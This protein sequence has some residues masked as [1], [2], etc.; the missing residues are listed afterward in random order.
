MPASCARRAAAARRATPSRRSRSA[1]QSA[2]WSRSERAGTTGWPSS[3]AHSGE[4]GLAD[5]AVAV[6]AELCANVQAVVAVLPELP[7]VRREP[8]AAPVGRA[9]RRAGGD[10]LLDRLLEL[11]ARREHRALPRGDSAGARAQRARLPV[12]IRLACGQVLD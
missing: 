8:E 4:K 6:A 3:A 5:P 12:G 7:R 10:D 2:G 11:R 1:M 9:R